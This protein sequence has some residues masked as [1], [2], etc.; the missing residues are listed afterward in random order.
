MLIGSDE[1][2]YKKLLKEDEQDF[3]KFQDDPDFN[4][5]YN[6]YKKSVLGKEKFKSLNFEENREEIKEDLEKYLNEYCKREDEYLDNPESL[7]ASYYEAVSGPDFNS[8]VSCEYLGGILEEYEDRLKEGIYFSTVV[9][10]FYDEYIEDFDINFTPNDDQIGHIYNLGSSDANLYFDTD[11]EITVL[12]KDYSFF[13]LFRYL[14]SDF[15][16][17]LELDYEILD[18]LLEIHSS[19]KLKYI[20]ILI[21]HDYD[22]KI[23]VYLRNKDEIID[24]FKEYI[25]E[26]NYLGYV[27]SDDN[28]NW[29]E[30]EE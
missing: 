2:I 9:N 22:Y 20:D 19:H 30:E 16:K 4:I 15:I 3:L 29:E 21:H 1:N 26:K 27:Q 8:W 10:D 14:P 13:E 23:A 6:E 12:N 24:L 25:K 17:E 5:N 7:N 18:Y 28:S 11:S